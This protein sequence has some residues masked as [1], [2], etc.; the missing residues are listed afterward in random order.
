MA[1]SCFLQ[2]F[3]GKLE[4]DEDEKEWSSDVECEWEKETEQETKRRLKKYKL[5]ELKRE[6]ELLGVSID[7][8]I[9]HTSRKSERKMRKVYRRVLMREMKI[10]VLGK[11]KA[12]D[13]R[14]N[15]QRATAKPGRVALVDERGEN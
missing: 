2:C 13:I 1:A 14:P 6:L 4:I 3:G 7:E 5:E 12:E 8:E 9:D 10:A 11:R 15:L